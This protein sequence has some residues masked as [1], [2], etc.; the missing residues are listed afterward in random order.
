MS[1]CLLFYSVPACPN[2]DMMSSHGSVS[3]TLPEE[4]RH[5]HDGGDIWKLSHYPAGTVVNVTCDE[6]TLLLD[7]YIKTCNVT[8]DNAGFWD[9]ELPQCESKWRRLLLKSW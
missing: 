6:N 5:L 8:E 2:E 3:I 9:T 4:P 7:N 1:S